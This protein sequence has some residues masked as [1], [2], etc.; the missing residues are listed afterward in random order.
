MT[1]EQV[2]IVDGDG[3]TIGTASKHEAHLAP[4]QFH[5]AVSVVIMD[6]NERTLLQRRG[7]DVYHFAN[8]WSNTCCTHPRP[9]ED[10]GVTAAR[11]L[12]EEMGIVATL[13]EVGT[14]RYRASDPTTGMIEHE[15]DHIFVGS[16]AG[17]P[18]PNRQLVSDWAWTEITILRQR[19]AADPDP[20]TPWLA[21]VLD[22]AHP[23]ADRP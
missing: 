17:A 7:P 5:R 10:P 20:Y 23:F 19:L 14:L 18:K 12:H 11:R 9:D 1:T 21:K 2:E 16:F 13:T 4:G 6:D 8:R 3:K 15:Y 22:L